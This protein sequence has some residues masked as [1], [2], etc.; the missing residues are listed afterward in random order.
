M[1]SD[2][3]YILPPD[4]IYGIASKGT[5]WGTKECMTGSCYAKQEEDLPKSQPGEENR[6]FGVPSIRNNIP[7]MYGLRIVLTFTFGPFISS[8]RRREF[9]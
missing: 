2:N 4:H 7:R 6:V 5:D 9:T 1:G 8:S 3:G